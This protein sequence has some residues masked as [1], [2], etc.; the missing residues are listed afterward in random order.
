M[1]ISFRQTNDT[2]KNSEA[3]GLITNHKSF[4]CAI[5]QYALLG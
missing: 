5:F 3:E 1:T 2:K 4:R